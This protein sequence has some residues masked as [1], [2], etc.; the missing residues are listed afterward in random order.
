MTERASPSPYHLVP[1]RLRLKLAPAKRDA[2]F[3][4]A[5]GQALAAV[6]GVRDV[7]VNTLTGSIVV[8]FDPQVARVDRIVEALRLDGLER[9]T[10]APALDAPAPRPRETDTVGA[11]SPLVNALITK[12]LETLVERGAIA[13]L[14][15]LV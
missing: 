3:A 9:K 10:F 6:A 7:H 12:A 8:R 14:A 15:A 2:T 1:G 4:R 5:V 11:A 13:L